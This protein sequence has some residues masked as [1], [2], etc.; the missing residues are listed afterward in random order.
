MS[1]HYADSPVKQKL[2]QA[3]TKFKQ[4]AAKNFTND[5]LGKNKNGAYTSNGSLNQGYEKADPDKGQYKGKFTKTTGRSATGRMAVEGDTRAGG[6]TWTFTEK[7]D[8]GNTIRQSGRSNTADRRQR[9]Y[10][11]RVGLGLA[12]G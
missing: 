4:V 2:R 12:G 11:V 5:D 6:K 1:R 7:D 3:G 10:D 9:Y 8:D